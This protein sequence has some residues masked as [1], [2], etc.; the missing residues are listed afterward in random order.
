[1]LLRDVLRDGFWGSVGFEGRASSKRGL[2]SK[3]MSMVGSITLTR[4]P[5]IKLDLPLLTVDVLEDL[6][7]LLWEA[8][9][10]RLI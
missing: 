6:E 7:L 4:L 5:A 2:F 8:I 1:M 9:E 3:S 10:A